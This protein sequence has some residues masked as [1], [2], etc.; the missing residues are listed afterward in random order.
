MTYTYLIQLIV[1]LKNTG[2]AFLLALKHTTY[3]LLL[4]GAGIYWLGVDSVNSRRDYF[5]YLCI[6]ASETMCHQK[7]MSVVD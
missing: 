4:D 6:P 5:V 7:R 2:P 3:Q 1:L